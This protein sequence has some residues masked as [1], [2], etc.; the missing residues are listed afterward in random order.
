MLEL[1]SISFIFT[2]LAKIVL[3]TITNMVLGFTWYSPIGFQ[4]QWIKAMRWNEEDVCKAH[5]ECSSIPYIMSNLG[6]LLSSILLNILLTAFN[7][8]KHQYLS[9]MLASL[10][11]CG[12]YAFNGWNRV[13]FTKKSDYKCQRTLYFIEN[14]LVF[15]RYALISLVLVSF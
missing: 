12:F 13:F 15:I 8:R 10:I 7:I 14:G 5:D 1:L 9:A 3:I 2:S 6:A 4:K 11:L